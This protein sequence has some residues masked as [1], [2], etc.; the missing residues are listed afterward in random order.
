MNSDIVTKIEK[1][2]VLSALP[3]IFLYFSKEIAGT[4]GIILI[5]ILVLLVITSFINFYP[6]YIHMEIKFTKKQKMKD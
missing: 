1:F 5:A 4:S 3:L 2:I 6:L